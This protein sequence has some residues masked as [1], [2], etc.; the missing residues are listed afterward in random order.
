MN[1]LIVRPDGIGDV[2][3]SIPV[4][5]ELRR[6]V[7][8]STI[9]FLTSPTAAP[10]LDHHPDVDYVRTM[11]WTDSLRTL[12][13]VFRDGVD[14][15]LFLKPFRRLMWAAFLARVPIRVATGFRWYSLLANRRMYEHRSEFLKHESEYNVE[16]LRGLGL[17]PQ[18]GSRPTLVV[19]EEE[20][21]GGEQRWE[22]M[23]GPRVVVH[24]GG[25]SARRWRPGHFRDLAVELARQGFGVVLTGSEKERSEFEREALS[26]SPLPVEISNLMGRLSVREL[27]AVIANA[28]VVVSGAT[29]PAHMAAAL[30]TAVV[31][32]FDPRRNNL[33]TRW[34]P[35]G[36]GL[37]LRPDVPTCEKC[38]GEVCPFWDCL[39]R[40]TVGHV[41]AAVRQAV[42]DP[43]PLTVIHI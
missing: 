43:S 22:A 19:S 42:K 23:P 36:A 41:A 17:H 38:I 37:L 33:P 11:R 31:S 25:H 35:L 9:G 2:I 30:G 10:L 8:G 32:L 27:M 4:A 29:G 6:L 18:T 34:R 14:A 39:D 40:L 12:C 24:P 15:A 16:M 20:R 3:L 13:A 26:G 28:D 7:P 1:V 21:R 5:T